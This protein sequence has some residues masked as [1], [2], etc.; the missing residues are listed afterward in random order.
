MNFKE[1][2]QKHKKLLVGSAIS[3]ITG[4]IIGFNGTISSADYNTLLSHKKQTTSKIESIEQELNSKK[5][6]LSN[7]EIEE[8]KISTEITALINAREEKERLAKLEAE[9]IE[10]EKKAEQDKIAKA[11]QDKINTEKNKES[12]INGNTSNKGNSN[13]NASN[14]DNSN[15]NSTG[16]KSNGNSSTTQNTPIGKMVWKTATGKK[17]HSKSKCGNSKTSVQITLE[18]AK[19]AGL[20]ACKNCYQ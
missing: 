1:K 20:T 11:E 17:Y 5:Q 6:S 12:N 18:Q 7:L 16:N 3:I 9:K 13:S 19:N 15:T 14:K 8:N 2:L 10:N 4:A